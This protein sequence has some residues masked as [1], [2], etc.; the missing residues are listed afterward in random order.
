VDVDSHAAR[1]FDIAER[2]AS[3]VWDFDGV[4]A[5]TEPVQRAAFAEVIGAFGSKPK[6]NFFDG[7]IGTPEEDI[8]A[9]LIRQHSLHGRSV[10]ELMES[11]SSVYMREVRKL[12]PAWYV[13]PFLKWASKNNKTSVIVSSGRARHVNALLKHWNLLDQYDA[14]FCNGLPK[15]PNLRTK[16]ERLEYVLSWYGGP[17]MIL[18]DNATYLRWAADI[19]MQTVAVRHSMNRSDIQCDNWT[20]CLSIEEGVPSA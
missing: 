19:G 18:E 1:L 5:D 12:E 17:F 6:K 16:F 4:V 15:H 9:E 2:C 7:F 8:W 14:V 13:S 10:G 3:I 11:R 20:L